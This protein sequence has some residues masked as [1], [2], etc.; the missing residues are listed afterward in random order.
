MRN[1]RDL[2][3]LLVVGLESGF[4]GWFAGRFFES[5]RVTRILENFIK[6]MEEEAHDAG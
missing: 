1:W 2:L 3:A 4:V 6:D 5:C